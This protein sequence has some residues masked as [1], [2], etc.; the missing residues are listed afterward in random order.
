MLYMIVSR[1]LDRAGIRKAQQGP[2]LL[3]HTA[4]SMWLANGIE[5]KQVQENLGHSNIGTTSRYL[6]L[7][8]AG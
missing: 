3:R 2:H 5:L 6:H 7:L 8:D 4:A 1:L